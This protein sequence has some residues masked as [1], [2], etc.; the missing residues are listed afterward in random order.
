MD[1]GQ[2]FT[3]IGYKHKKNH[4]CIKIQSLFHWGTTPLASK[5]LPY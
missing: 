2:N 1:M 3:E 4:V 5:H